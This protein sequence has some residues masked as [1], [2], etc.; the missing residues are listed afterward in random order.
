[1]LL[2]SFR[3]IGRQAVRF[4][5]LCRLLVRRMPDPL[6]FLGDKAYERQLLFYDVPAGRVALANDLALADAILTDR[7]GVFP[8]SAHLQ[9]LLRPLIGRGV[10]G[11]GGGDAVKRRR[12]TYLKVLS[13]VGNDDVERVACQLLDEYLARWLATPEGIA[14]PREMSRLTID[15]VTSIVFGE[16]FAPQESERFVDLFFDYHQRCNP[17]VVFCTPGDPASLE[18]FVDSMRLGEVGDEMRDM[19]RRRFLTPWRAAVRSGQGLPAFMQALLEETGRPAG[20]AAEDVL[21]D[22]IAVMVLAGHETSASVLSW[23]FWE[24]SGRPELAGDLL[25]CR[26]NPGEL[27][28]RTDALVQEGLRMYPPIA[29]YLR[30]AMENLECR[31]KTIAR[32]SAVAVSPW[33]I[34]RHRNFWPNPESFCPARWFRREAS[35]NEPRA[36]FIPFGFGSRFCPGKYFAEAEMRAIVE[37]VV[38]RAQLLRVGDRVPRPLGKLTARPDYDF[39][40][41]FVPR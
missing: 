14:V 30:D 39:R 25:N 28:E 24:I 38:L 2:Q 27:R 15:I 18:H 21:L 26:D 35:A 11:Q 16:R 32:G 13:K 9:E 4:P 36:K 10:F 33:T 3:W 31:G 12:K 1:M 6:R 23:L 22:E 29:F 40:L 19:M 5:V 37:R 41:H 17:S 7:A 8:K 20:A 34:Q